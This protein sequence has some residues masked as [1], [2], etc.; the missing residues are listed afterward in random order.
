MTS[1]TDRPATNT[2]VVLR[3]VGELRT[4][5]RAVPE[6]APGDVLVRVEVVTICG[7]DVHYYERGRI[8]GFVVE[9]PLVLGHETAG[10]VT[11]VG[12]GVDPDRVG[13]RVALEPGIPCGRCTSC[14][15]GRYNLCPHMRFFATPPVDGS[16]QQYVVLPSFL[17]HDVPT[18]LSFEQAALIEPLAVAVM[19]CRAARLRGGEEVLVTGAGAIG[20]LCAQTARAFGAGRVWL[21]DVA[22]ERL[23]RA[24][25]FGLA[26]TVLPDEVA[27]LSPDVL[28][29]CSGAAAALRS[30]LTAL[31]PGG[32]AVAIGLGGDP[33][34]S[35]PLGAM[36]FKEIT[37]TSTF[38]YANA[39]PAAIELARDGR[40]RLTGL[41]GAEF[42]LDQTDRAMR[43]AHDRPTVLRA[44][45]YPQRRA[46]AP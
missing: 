44:A 17:A 2:A 21:S 28:L 12:A 10:V 13:S 4:E 23:A 8:G 11:A 20:V 26:D 19:A 15:T 34:V 38:R 33:D 25:D 46:V 22:P 16:L 24:G 43:A 27:G 32:T 29:E 7:S 30:G 42:P 45:V 37:L 31:T 9:A 40:V 14:L 39:Y 18:E 3:S 36:Q 5:Q 1:V 41:V 35:L 6:P